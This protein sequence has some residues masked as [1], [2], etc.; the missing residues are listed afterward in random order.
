MQIG[1]FSEEHEFK[2]PPAVGPETSVKIIGLADMGQYNV[3]YFD[4]PHGYK[5]S[6]GTSKNI[7]LEEDVDLVLH[8]GDISYAQG[9]VADWDVF[10]DQLYPLVS[11]VPYMVSLYPS[12]IWLRICSRSRQFPETMNATTQDR[13]IATTTT[14]QEAS[15][16]SR[17]REDFRCQSR[18]S[19]SHG[20]PSTSDPSTSSP[21]AASTTSNLAQSNSSKHVLRS[22]L[23]ADART[24]QVHQRRSRIRGSFSDALGHC[25]R[26]SPHVPRNYTRQTWWILVCRS[27]T[28]KAFRRL[29]LRKWS[30][31]LDSSHLALNSC[32]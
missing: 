9:Y 14:T 26:P 13:A 29:F 31:I 18:K 3:D 7:H 20:T 22:K 11:K 6:L 10:F 8:V 4:N 15:V 17:T 23:I 1:G 28:P 2:A 16:G 25:L 12:L 19:T 21:S 32:F 30:R 27:R 24:V 5:P